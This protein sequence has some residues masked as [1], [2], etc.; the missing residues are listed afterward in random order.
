MQAI[1]WHRWQRRD[2]ARMQADRKGIASWS[3]GTAAFHWLCLV[4]GDHATIAA[5]VLESN[6]TASKLPGATHTQRRQVLNRPTKTAQWHN[7]VHD[8]N[9]LKYMGNERV[10]NVNCTC[11]YHSQQL[12]PI[13]TSIIAQRNT[14]FPE[15][16]EISTGLTTNLTTSLTFPSIFPRPTTKSLT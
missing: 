13:T 8:L 7:R 1:H 14:T 3:R 15:K 5:P 9:T 2:R 4:A 6:P 10:F 12:D 16:I 11:N